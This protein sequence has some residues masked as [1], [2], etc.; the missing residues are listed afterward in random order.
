MSP[1]A[2]PNEDRFSP[3]L[4]LRRQTDSDVSEIFDDPHFLLIIG[5]AQSNDVV[6]CALPHRLVSVIDHVDYGRSRQALRCGMVFLFLF[7]DEY[8]LAYN[9]FFREMNKWAFM[10]SFSSAIRPG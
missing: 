8:E 4:T 7:V 3:D 1:L 6:Q 2:T 9:G 5:G 10:D